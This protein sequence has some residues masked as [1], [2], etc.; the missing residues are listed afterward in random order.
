[1]KNYKNLYLIAL[2][3]LALLNA[4]APLRIVE[5]LKKDEN[6]IGLSL[7]G[8]M[9]NVPRVATM[10]IPFTNVFYGRGVTDKLSLHG[11]WYPT[12]SIFG[13][14]QIDIGATYGLWK[15]KRDKQGVSAMINA[16]IAMDFFEYKFRTWP[17]LDVHYYFKYRSRNLGDPMNTKTE[18]LFYAGFSTWYELLGVKAHEQLQ[19]DRVLP[20]FNI[21]HDLNWKQWTL[22]TE[23][24][25]MAPFSSNENKVV[26]YISIT[27]NR[28]VLGVY[29]GLI[30]KF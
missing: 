29:L 19:T 13:V 9:I 25:L 10:P 26:D 5:P 12:A 18:N 24:S 6:I 20:T 7:G 3:M 15:D 21:G 11:G 8:P 1:M 23:L 16:N 28:G 2:L 4:C 22:K 27:G 14:G 30:R 17:E